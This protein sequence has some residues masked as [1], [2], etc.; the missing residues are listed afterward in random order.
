VAGGSIIAAR[1]RLASVALKTMTVTFLLLACCLGQDRGGSPPSYAFEISEI[2]GRERLSGS[3]EY[4]GVCGRDFYPD[5]PKIQSASG[6]E[7]SSVDEIRA[8]FAVDG[9]MQV[10]QKGD[11]KVRMVETDVPDDLLNVKIHHVVLPGDVFGTTSAKF[12]ILKTPEV[13]NFRI[14]HNIGPRADWGGGFSFEGPLSKPVPQV[15]LN[16]V[17]VA[18]AFDKVLEMYPGYW[19]YES[20]RDKDGARIAYFGF[21][22]NA[23]LSFYA[24]QQQQK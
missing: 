24:S 9:M 8:M 23:P 16:D 18:E 12:A 5:L 13:Q 10:T 6:K 17:T 14:E 11:G 2:L 3:L 22:K 21:Y 15:E 4:W 7:V 19:L 1:A 20:C